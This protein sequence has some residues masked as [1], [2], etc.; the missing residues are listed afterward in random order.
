MDSNK[1]NARIQLLS[2]NSKPEQSV[3]LEIFMPRVS[4]ERSS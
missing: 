1:M 4:L 2:V 3:S